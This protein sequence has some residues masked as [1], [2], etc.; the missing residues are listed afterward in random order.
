MACHSTAPGER[1]FERGVVDR[2]LSP[3][4]QAIFEADVGAGLAAGK[5]AGGGVPLAGQ[6]R[7]LRGDDHPSFGGGVG[8][9]NLEAEHAVDGLGLFRDDGIPGLRGEGDGAT[10]SPARP[11][12]SRRPENG[13]GSVGRRGVERSMAWIGWNNCAHGRPARS[14]AWRWPIPWPGRRSCGLGKY[15]SAK[16]SGRM[17]GTDAVAAG[18]FPFGALK[19]TLQDSPTA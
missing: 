17:S 10:Q 3:Q 2:K 8:C 16:R 19:R 4:Q 9:M 12:P 6:L 7:R 1:M 18:T 13:G 5:Q 14:V 15:R 11:G